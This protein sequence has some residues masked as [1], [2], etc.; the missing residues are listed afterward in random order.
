MTQGL[1]KKNK[2][3]SVDEAEV[4]GFLYVLRPLV[5]IYTKSRMAG[6]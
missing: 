5:S 4:I 3:S 6:P 1:D 2:T